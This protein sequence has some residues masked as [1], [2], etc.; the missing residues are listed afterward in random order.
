MV[1]TERLA[2]LEK[3]VKTL[4]RQMAE[5]SKSIL[6]PIES[7]EPDPYELIRTVT[8]LLLPD[9]GSW[10][11]TIVDANINASG[12]TIPEAVAHLK[13]MMIDLF[14]FLRKEPKTKLGKQ[15]SHQLAFLQSVMRKKVR[16]AA[17]R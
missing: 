12:E 3:E 4:K 9:D 5:G 8:I 1:L 2:S 10:I 13:D 11:A 6:V 15:P 16:R 17:H 14:E 7:F